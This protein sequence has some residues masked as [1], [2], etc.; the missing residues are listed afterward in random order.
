MKQQINQG[1]I[2]NAEAKS[3]SNFKASVRPIR[4]FI[5]YCFLLNQGHINDKS[6][7]IHNSICM[8]HMMFKLWTSAP[9]GYKI[10]YL[11][12]TYE[13]QSNISSMHWHMYNMH[14]AVC[15]YHKCCLIHHE[16]LWLQMVSWEFKLITQSILCGKYTDV[17]VYVSLFFTAFYLLISFPQFLVYEIICMYPDIS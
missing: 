5:I 14:T 15:C 9:A 13:K 12:V 16:F 17:K 2:D 10:D 11:L 7:K 6:I 3:F 4:M 1:N 8:F